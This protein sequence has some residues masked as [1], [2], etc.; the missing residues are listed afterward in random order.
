M[1]VQSIKTFGGGTH[2]HLGQFSSEHAHTCTLYCGSLCS[3]VQLY[4]TVNTYG[5]PQVKHLV[6]LVC[7]RLVCV[8]VCV[9]VCMYVCV[10]VYIYIYILLRLAFSHDGR[11]LQVSIFCCIPKQSSCHKHYHTHSLH[12]RAVFCCIS[13][14]LISQCGHRMPVRPYIFQK[15]F[16]CCCM[17]L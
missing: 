8:C 4:V 2:V 1:L 14:C 13:G 10:C 11:L 12:P 3:V 9:C 17:C 5:L 16:L 15:Y 7:L 6:R